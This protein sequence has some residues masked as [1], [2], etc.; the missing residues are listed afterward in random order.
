M[1]NEGELRVRISAQI[2]EKGKNLLNREEE[3]SCGS[4]RRGHHCPS[5]TCPPTDYRGAGRGRGEGGFGK[6]YAR[7]YFNIKHPFALLGE[8]RGRRGINMWRGSEIRLRKR[9]KERRE[10]VEDGK[11]GGVREGDWE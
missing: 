9:G 8:G 5:H 10:R 2:W 6:K 7:I 4:G 1:C 3:E 11:E